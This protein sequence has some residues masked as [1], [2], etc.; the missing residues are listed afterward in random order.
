MWPASASSARLPDMRPPITLGDHV[1]RY[2]RQGDIQAASA[3]IAKVVA[4]A[5]VTV[6]VVTVTAVVSMV[7]MSVVIVTIVVMMVVLSGSMAG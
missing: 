7:M 4:V 5:V 2:Q 3:G 6:V 1:G